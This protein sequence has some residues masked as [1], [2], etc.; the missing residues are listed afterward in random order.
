LS[1]KILGRG[2]ASRGAALMPDSNIAIYCCFY[3]RQ[4]EETKKATAGMLLDYL[5]PGSSLAQGER[6]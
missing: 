5:G 4:R 2:N 6:E 3:N 1:K